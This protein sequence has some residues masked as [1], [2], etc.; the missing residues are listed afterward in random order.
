MYDILLT[1]VLTCL[2]WMFGVLLW[3]LT[4]LGQQPYVEVDP[5]EIAGYL[6]DGY[7]LAQPNNCPDEL[8]V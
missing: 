3:E 6:R 4:T 5:F 8:Y 1:H 7:R 2:Q